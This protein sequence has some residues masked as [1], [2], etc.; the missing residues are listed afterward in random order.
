[1]RLGLAWHRT[2]TIALG[3][4]LVGSALIYE[5]EFDLLAHASTGTCTRGSTVP[6]YCAEAVPVG[7]EATAGNEP[8]SR[9]DPPYGW[10]V[11]LGASVLSFVCGAS[12][13]KARG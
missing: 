6:Q 7:V 5:R 11:L 2:K 9:Q 8:A 1:M 12:Y 3:V 10:I 4:A 13:Q